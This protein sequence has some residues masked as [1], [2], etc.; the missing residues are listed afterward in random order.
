MKKYIKNVC[1]ILLCIIL[2]N[3][4]F[5]I[6]TSLASGWSDTMFDSIKETA[7]KGDE[8]GAGDKV[9]NVATAVVFVAKIVALAVAM[10]MLLVIAIKYMFAA[11]GE[12]ADLKKNVIVYVVGAII[13]FAVSG[14]LQLIEQIAGIFGEN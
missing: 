14:I 12:K 3:F 13:L 2:L 6:K 10:I 4:G 1:I 5:C 8:T 7:D 9:E 11:P